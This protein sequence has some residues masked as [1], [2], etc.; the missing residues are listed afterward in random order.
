MSKKFI[1]VSA[2]YA[3]I[4][5][6]GIAITLL[7]AGEIT[8]RLVVSMCFIAFSFL[9]MALA[10]ILNLLDIREN[11]MQNFAVTT[12]SIIYFIVTCVV[13]VAINILGFT[14]RWFAVV[15]ILVMALGIVGML[16]GIL[17]KQHI[18]DK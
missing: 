18:E 9:A 12:I 6:A 15:E 8:A 16:F 4:L 13:T 3:V 10:S 14:L 7:L 2:I 1:T 11:V 17:G 5:V